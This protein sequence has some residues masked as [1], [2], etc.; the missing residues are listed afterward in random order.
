MTMPA[1]IPTRKTTTLRRIIGD[2]II[3]LSSFR[4]AD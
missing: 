1:S 3:R 2:P 4:R